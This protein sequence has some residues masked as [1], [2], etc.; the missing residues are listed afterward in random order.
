MNQWQESNNMIF[1]GNKVL[2]YGKVNIIKESTAYFTPNYENVIEE[3]DCL[4]DLGI[5]MAND[6]SFSNMLNMFAPR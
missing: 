3:K 4:R 2:R 5:I 6:A 1:N